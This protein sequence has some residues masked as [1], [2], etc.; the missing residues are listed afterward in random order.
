MQ[1]V[2]SNPNGLKMPKVPGTAVNVCI[3]TRKG[4]DFRTMRGGLNKIPVKGY[5]TMVTFTSD[6]VT[7][8]WQP[9]GYG[10]SFRVRFNNDETTKKFRLKLEGMSASGKV[11]HYETIVE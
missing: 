9:L 1:P 6:K 5:S 2:A 7:L 11:I 3:Y 4:K 8:F 10:N